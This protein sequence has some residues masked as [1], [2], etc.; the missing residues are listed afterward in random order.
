MV[1]FDPAGF[2][3]S[4]TRWKPVHR[5]H[6]MFPAELRRWLSD[7]GSLTARIRAGCRSQFSVQ[8]IN[9]RRM[10]PFADEALSLGLAP[11]HWVHVREVLL[12]CGQCPWVFARTL[13]PEHTLQGRW[14]RLLRLGGRPLG[15]LLFRDSEVCRG[16][17]EI[18]RLAFG[19]RLHERIRRA[20]GQNSSI[21]WGRR[22]LYALRHRPILVH[23]CFLP[24]I[25][26]SSARASGI[27]A[28]ASGEGQ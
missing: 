27:L 13:I 18:A 14:R 23:E 26:A 19:D 6:S 4:G 8:V 11:E 10:K 15:E 2:R 21:I 1:K 16:P 9:N 20:T 7:P 5:A 3:R 24:G 28:R 22:T 12:M 17:I 25:V